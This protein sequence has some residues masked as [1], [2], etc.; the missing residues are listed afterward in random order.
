M[1]GQ[2]REAAGE[3][4]GIKRINGATGRSEMRSGYFILR[5]MT[6]SLLRRSARLSTFPFAS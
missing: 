2:A 5:Q 1:D 4:W 3:L 6:S